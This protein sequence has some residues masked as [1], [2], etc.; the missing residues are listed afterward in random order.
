M[1]SAVMYYVLSF[2]KGRNGTDVFQ[3]MKHPTQ[4]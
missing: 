3:L 2:G 4:W 1:M